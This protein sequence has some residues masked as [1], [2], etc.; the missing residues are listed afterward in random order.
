MNEKV[1]DSINFLLK[2]YKRLIQKKK[3][4]KLNNFEK[5]TLESLMKFLGQKK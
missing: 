2:E 4:K 5:K 3:T 1:S